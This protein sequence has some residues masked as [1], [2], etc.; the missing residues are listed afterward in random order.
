[1]PHAVLAERL[2]AE[3]TLGCEARGC[4]KVFLAKTRASD[5]VE[6]WALRAAAEA[7]RIGWRVTGGNA[8]VCPTH[9]LSK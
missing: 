4:G 5:P 7:E 3:L 1:M 6:P 9:A 2:Y 8:I